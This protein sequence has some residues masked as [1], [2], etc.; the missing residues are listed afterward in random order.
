ML[1]KIQPVLPA[2]VRADGDAPLD[3][4]VVRRKFA[5]RRRDP[6]RD[7]RH[8][9]AGGSRRGLRRDR[10]GQ[11]GRG[12]Q[13]DLG[14]AR[15]RRHRVHAVLLRRRRGPARLPGRRRARHD[16][17]LHPSPRRRALRLRHGARRHQCDARAGG[18]GEARAAQLCRSSRTRSSGSP[19]RRARGARG[20][21][22]P[23][24]RHRIV[25]RRVHLRY[26]GTDSALVVG[27]AARAETCEAQFETDYRKRYSFLMPGRALIAESVSVE[28]IGAR[29]AH[30]SETPGSAPRAAVRRSPR[31]GSRM[32][33]G[34]ARARDAGVPPRAACARATAIAGPGDHRREPTPPPWSSRGGGREV[35][36]LDHLV[37]ERV[38][39]RARSARRS[40][41][42]ST[43]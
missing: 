19:R 36:P 30:A 22:S 43:R 5:A 37:L 35:T 40:A 6:R 8:A 24:E 13:E 31:S 2:R 14:A 41:R 18:R 7:R 17:H 42:A 34:G 9:H 38:E 15:P 12:D 32:F 3:A 27:F 16:A 4:D 28:A 39:R 29:R 23:P 25:A 33:S 1:G 20:R 11:H 26:E 10:R 21:A